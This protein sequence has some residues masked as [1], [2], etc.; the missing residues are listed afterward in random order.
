MV[1]RLTEHTERVL[2]ENEGGHCL[3]PRTT[4]DIGGHQFES[5]TDRKLNDILWMH[6]AHTCHNVM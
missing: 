6:A 4:L 2:T 5:G 1:E 3:W